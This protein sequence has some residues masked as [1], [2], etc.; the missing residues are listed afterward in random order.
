MSSRQ[1]GA[2]IAK[3]SGWIVV[4]LLLTH[5]GTEQP[6]SSL[7]T[8]RFWHFWSEP[9]QRS[10]IQTIVRQFEQQ[11]QCRVELSELSWNDGKAKLFAAFNAGTAPD[12]L[13]LGS[14][15][16]AQFSAAG[17]LADLSDSVDLARFLPFTHPPARWE[18][19]TY[20]VPWVVDTRVLF[21][22]DSLLQE[23]GVSAQPPADVDQWYAQSQAVQQLPDAYGTGVNG[24]DPHR[25]YKKVLPFLWSNGGELLDS[26]GFPTFDRPE[27]IEA[28]ERYVQ[29]AEVG[30]VETQRRLDDLFIQGKIG[31]WISGSWLLDRIPKENPSLRYRLALVP[32]MPG[33]ESRSFAGGEYLAIAKSTK[34]FR[35][36]LQ[37]VRYLTS[38]DVALQFCKLV[39]SAGFPADT[40][41][42]AD[43]YFATVPGR[44]V[45][46]Q[47]LRFARMTPVH[48][49]WLEFE[50][51]FEEA[52]TRVLYGK[53]TA[54]EALRQAQQ[55]AVQI[56]QRRR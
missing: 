7:P 52:V 30:L 25:L 22:N 40:A 14:D 49:Q 5:C 41:T 53:Q 23:A 17:V 3:L 54:A 27:N 31:F 26:T 37:L 44:A 42:F 20:A 32:P 35:L 18:G 46:A 56:A 19:K 48:P 15:W 45:F 13:E 24:A 36:A 8:V 55:Q 4:A 1:R 6:Q 11:Y 16:V 12:V 39:S 10:A 34:Q 21:L 43:P 2:A 51:L 29:F 33:G 50:R 47:Q 28:V 9:A 38:A